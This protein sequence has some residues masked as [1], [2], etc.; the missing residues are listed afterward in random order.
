MSDKI[1]NKNDSFGIYEVVVLIIITC[2]VSLIMGFVIGNNKS[3]CDEPIEDEVLEEIISNYKKITNEYEGKIDKKEI[4]SGAVNGMLSA[5]GD[6]YSNILN[7]DNNIFYTTLNGSY[8]GIGVEIINDNDNNIMVVGVL[9]NSPAEKAGIKRN[10]IIKSIDNIDM[11][12]KDKSELS[13]YV[14]TNN[15]EKYTII[16]KRNDEEMKF[17]LSKEVVSIKSVLVKTIEKENKKIGYIYISIFSG[18]TAE[19]FK[20]ALKELDKQ[21]VDSLIIDVRENSGGHLTTVVNMLSYMLSS[22]KVIYQMEKDGKTTVYK[23]KGKKN[24]EYPIVLLQNKNSAS[25]SELFVSALSEQLGAYI[26]GETSYGKGTVQEVNYLSNGDTYKFTTKKWKTSKGVW[27]N[28]KGIKPDLEISLDENYSLN[29][30][31]ETD[32]QLQ[33]AIKYLIEK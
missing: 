30:S 22:D 18:T 1:K 28:K 31:D 9:E 5:L 4:L 12:N 23:S 7:D 33:A 16:V 20:K 26:I 24:I 29:P 21:K 27:I 13:N 15:K 6:E 3:T 19:Q 17:E 11:T 2:I 8:E 14:K 10:D 32:N 25:A